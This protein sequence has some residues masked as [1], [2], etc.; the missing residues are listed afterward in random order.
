[1]GRGLFILAKMKLLSQCNLELVIW[2][3]FHM[4]FKEGWN[5]RDLQKL[6]PNQ[7]NE[8]FCRLNMGRGRFLLV[9]KVDIIVLFSLVSSISYFFINKFSKGRNWFVEKNTYLALPGFSDLADFF[10]P[11]QTFWKKATFTHIQILK[12]RFDDTVK[13]GN[14]E[15]FSHRKIVP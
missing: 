13:L 6:Y 9:L 10:E 15:L 12:I 8:A 5:K 4:I 1:M 11:H 7:G 14:K 3:I 2:P